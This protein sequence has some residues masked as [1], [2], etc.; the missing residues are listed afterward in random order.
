MLLARHS[1][2]LS[3][4]KTE[5]AASNVEA[6][7]DEFVNHILV[8]DIPHAVI[9]DC[10]ASEKIAEKYAGFLEKGIH[11]ITPNKHAN[12][13][14][15]EYYKKLKSMTENK[16]QHYLYEATVCAGLPVINTLQDILR[17]G[18]DIEKIEGIVSG[19]LSYIFS[20]LAKDRNFSEVVIEAKQKGF[21]EPDPRQDLSG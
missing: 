1:V 14:D 19:T 15:I 7:L 16:G 13:G 11:V 5:L 12:A 3:T 17:T 2:D 20:E 10:T 21:T 18:D 8:N 9:I 4:W 6:N